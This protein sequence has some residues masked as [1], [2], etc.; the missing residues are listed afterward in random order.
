MC[1]DLAS[2]KLP[3]DEHIMQHCIHSK[4]KMA[5]ALKSSENKWKAENQLSTWK[6]GKTRTLVSSVHNH[7]FIL[8]HFTTSNVQS[9]RAHF[10]I[11]SLY[12][13]GRYLLLVILSWIC[14]WRKHS[15]FLSCIY[16]ST[17]LHA[18]LLT[19]ATKLISINVSTQNFCQKGSSWGEYNKVDRHSNHRYSS[20]LSSASKT[21]L[22]NC[23]H[24]PHTLRRYLEN[25]LWSLSWDILLW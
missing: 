14:S 1:C 7:K 12:T 25:T 3:W 11:E 18:I 24:L 8:Y 15:Y 13:V 20:P 19:T 23:A 2:E 6:V 9:F 10:V 16:V 5:I 21:R 17:C 4:N 22:E